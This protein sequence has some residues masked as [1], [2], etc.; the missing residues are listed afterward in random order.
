MN[1][2]SERP[3]LVSVYDRA[4]FDETRVSALVT[5]ASLVVAVDQLVDEGVE[6]VLL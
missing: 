4:V 6:T 2:A 3:R 5:E 1:T